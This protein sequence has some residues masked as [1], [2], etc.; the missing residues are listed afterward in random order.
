[1][2]GNGVRICAVSTAAGRESHAAHCAHTLVSR[3]ADTANGDDD[4]NL[5]ATMN[6]K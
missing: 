6:T 3:N 1:M 4:D 5:H 2:C